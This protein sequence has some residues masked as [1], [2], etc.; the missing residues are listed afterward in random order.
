[1]S[2]IRK[3]LLHQYANATEGLSVNGP[4]V[5]ALIETIDKQDKELAALRTENARLKEE[6]H[7]IPRS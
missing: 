6:P 2:E 7:D 1:M 5:A 3:N 4:Q